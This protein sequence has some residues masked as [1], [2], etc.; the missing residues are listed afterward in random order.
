MAHNHAAPTYRG[1]VPQ[2]PNFATVATETL[3]CLSF[4]SFVIPSSTTSSNNIPCWGDGSNNAGT[5]GGP[6]RS[7][8]VVVLGLEDNIN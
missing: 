1:K 7:R 2:R 8:C 5:L 3:P 4:S 6:N